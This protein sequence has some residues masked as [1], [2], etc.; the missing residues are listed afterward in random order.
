MT[1][2]R[3]LTKANRPGGSAFTAKVHLL[4]Q[5][6]TRITLL[7]DKA[8]PE[9]AQHVIEFPG[10]AVEVSRTSD[11]D[12]WAHILVHRGAVLE[13]AGGRVSARGEVIGHRVLRDRGFEELDQPDAIE[14]IAVLIRRCPPVTAGLPREGEWPC[15]AAVA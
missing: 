13:D 12:Y 9:S 15:P 2:P 14:Q 11:G 7:G 8:R 5:A 6:P 10:G 1:T 4:G 3:R